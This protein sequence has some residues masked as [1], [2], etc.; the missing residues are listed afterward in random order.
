MK[1]ETLDKL[2]EVRAYFL[3][4]MPKEGERERLM[5]DYLDD[6]IDEAEK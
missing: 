4:Q 6:V 2:F 5:L 3:E 1:P